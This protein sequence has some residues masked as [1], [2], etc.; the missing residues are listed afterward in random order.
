MPSTRA[1]FTGLVLLASNIGIS[2][3]T[4]FT[5]NNYITGGCSIGLGDVCGCNAQM[6]ITDKSCTEASGIDKVDLTDGDDGCGGTLE[7]NWAAPYYQVS[8]ITH[9]GHCAQGC[10]LNSQNPGATCA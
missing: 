3:A 10:D 8:Y 2:S 5:L 1:L 6:P 7:M 9:D 4:S